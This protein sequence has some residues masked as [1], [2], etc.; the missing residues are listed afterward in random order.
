MGFDAYMTLSVVALVVALLAATRLAPDLILGG[1]L[2]ILFLSGAIGAQDALA[3]F[4]NEGMITIGLLFVVAAGVIETGA[5]SWLAER[6]FGHTTSVVRAT[7]RLMAPTAGLSAFVNNTPVVAMLIPA[8][9]EWAKKHG[10]ASSKLM[11]PLSYAA[12]L[13]G[14]CTLVGTSTNLLVN[15][16]LIRVY[17]AQQATGLVPEVPRGLGMFDIAWVGVPCA[18]AGVA[19]IVAGSHWLLPNRQ[20]AMA[21]VADP[22]QYTIE[23]QVE[24]G[25]PLVGRSIEQ[26]G[27]RHLRGLYLAEI[28][29]DE[30]VLPAVGPD[31]LLAPTTIWSS[32]ASSIR[33]SICKRF[34]G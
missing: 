2:M 16:M 24:P 4:S 5:I 18:I 1:G 34:A 27:L 8:V 22:R 28:Y 20:P 11:I 23:M 6:L 32:W 25:C 33:W 9:N 15:G 3:G 21:S 19:L 17:E 26:A 29:R 7:W 10:I 13:G 14:I 31:E 30:M 12:I